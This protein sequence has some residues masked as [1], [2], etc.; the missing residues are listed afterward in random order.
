MCKDFENANNTA[1]KHFASEIK[2]R[3]GWKHSLKYAAASGGD[4]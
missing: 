2:T 1:R 4:S 3:K